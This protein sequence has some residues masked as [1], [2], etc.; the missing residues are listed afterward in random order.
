MTDA[1]HQQHESN[2]WRI[3]LAKAAVNNW[4]VWGDDVS[5]AFLYARRPTDKPLYAAYTLYGHCVLLENFIHRLHDSP[6]AFHKLVQ[7]HMLTEQCFTA[8]PADPCVYHKIDKKSGEEVHVRVH[9]DDFLSTGSPKMLS[10]FRLALAARFKTTGELAKTHYGLYISRAGKGKTI[11]FGCHSYMAR[12]LEAY[13]LTDQ[14]IVSTRMSNTFDL[15]KLKGECTDQA[16]QSRYISLVGS[17]IFPAATCRPDIAF[18]AHVLP[19]HIEHP[20][21]RH[22]DAA[23]RVLGYLRGTSDY[24]TVFGGGP[25]MHYYGSSDAPHLTQQGTHD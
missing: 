24:G 8:D 20:D 18:A 25:T 12:K 14:Q 19:R 11:K 21:Q 5:Q 23:H 3:L 15:P 7:H 6:L 2:Q 22:I 10:E 1:T 13:S 4:E 17:L 9:V 16:L